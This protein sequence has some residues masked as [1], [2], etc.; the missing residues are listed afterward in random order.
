[1]KYIREFKWIAST[2]DDKLH[3][4]EDLFYDCEEVRSIFGNLAPYAVPQ[5]T[6]KL[7]LEKIGFKTQVTLDDALA[8]FSSWRMSK[9]SLVTSTAQMSKFYAFISDKIEN[10]QITKDFVSSPFIFI[11]F[12][13]SSRCNDGVPGILLSSKDV[14]WHDPTGCTD[15]MKEMSRLCTSVRE[16][17]CL[18]CK[19]L[20]TVYPG[21]HDFFVKTCGV[22]TVPPFGSYLP[23]LLQLSTVSLPSQSAY[24]VFRVF[25]KWSDDLNAGLVK[26]EELVDLKENLLKLENTILPT[27][28]DKWVS[29]HPSYGLLCWSDDEKL[30]QQ[31]KHYDGVEFLNFGELNNQEKEVLS[32]KVA[33]FLQK[34]G[35]H[36]LSQVVSREAIFY[37]TTDNKEKASLINWLFPFAQRYLYKQYPDVFECACLLQ[38]NIFY[39]SHTTDYH[40][41]FLEFSRLFFN[42]SAELHLANFLHMITTMADTGSTIEQTEFFVVNS[43]KVPKLPAEEPVWFSSSLSTA[44]SGE[45]LQPISTS[46]MN[47]TQN[48]QT[49]PRRKPGISPNWPPTDWKTA[50]DFNY[51]INNNLRTRSLSLAPHDGLKNELCKSLENAIPMEDLLVPIEIE[52]DFLIEED[53][54]TKSTIVS[55]ESALVKGKAVVAE[56]FDSTDWQVHSDLDLENKLPYLLPTLADSSASP[57][58]KRLSWHSP[59]ENP[60]RRTGR[61]G[62]FLSYKYFTEKLGSANVKWVNEETETGLPYDLIIGET[63]E[64]QEYIE[65]KTTKF[66][67]K[68]WFEISTREWQFASLKGDTFS[69]AHVVLLSQKKATINILKNP[70]KLCQQ[71]ALHLTVLMSKQLRNSSTPLN[72]PQ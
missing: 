18:P 16:I 58:K 30:K 24:L 15:K 28:G 17:G 19:A 6:S 57:E 29:L 46:P 37:G 13:N 55:R 72:G 41:M 49:G 22:P 40:T 14:Y 34:L 5:V 45:A 25:L 23:I 59:D 69:I 1:M 10:L 4:S 11:P 63:E 38:G 43:Q 12:D 61:L 50:P 9:P 3:H 8:I 7:L 65:V 52:G 47:I 36:P 48:V 60:A 33:K 31:F 51:S 62:E 56:N 42:G 27:L 54:L 39:V 71:K 67:N 21:L 66:A 35:V 68:N 70:L 26:T 44:D 20:T 32:G 53:L 2:L 64:S